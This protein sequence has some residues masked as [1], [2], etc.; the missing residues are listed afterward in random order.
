[1]R[2]VI[3]DD[4]QDCLHTLDCYAALRGHE[5]ARHRLPARDEAHFAELLRD[6]DAVVAV[7][8]RSAFPRALLERLPRLKL[9]SQVGRSTHHIDLAACAERGVT[10][11]AGTQASPIAPAELTWAVI[12]A[13][14]RNVVIEAERMRRGEWPATLS[15]RLAGGT[16]G[17]FGLGTI[18]ELVARV[19]PAFG[20]RVLVWGRDN[21]RALA[22]TRGYDAA[23][24][25]D[26]FFAESD[27]LSLHVRMTDATR[28]IVTRS[29]LARMKPTAL[30]VNT[31]RAGL[32]EPGALE[33]ALRA[34]RPGYAAVDVYDHEPVTGGDHP[35]LKMVNV[36]CMPH[37]G[38]AD[39]D[40]FELYFG[41]AFRQVADFFAGQPVNVVG[42]DFRRAR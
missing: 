10:V 7:R 27:V 25:R 3:P 29:D 31:S 20:M 16:L 38:W 18:G 2:V 22:R 35:L 11:C 19:G 34:G 15:H 33:D 17:I 28:G 42:R 8:E 39:R 40:T 23:T 36:V 5:V 9:I 12:L 4:Y 14:R 24:S 21:S 32:V 30:F 41:E 26:Q 6:A 1:M 13:A 37:L